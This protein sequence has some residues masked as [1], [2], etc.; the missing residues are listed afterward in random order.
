M[1]SSNPLMPH[2]Q[3]TQYQEWRFSR[4]QLDNLYA[5]GVDALTGPVKTWLDTGELYDAYLG[6]WCTWIMELE[7]VAREARV[8]RVDD[9]D[10]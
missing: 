10:A 5:K 4:Q 1:E 3:Y 8:G 2:E 7:G 6:R 9:E